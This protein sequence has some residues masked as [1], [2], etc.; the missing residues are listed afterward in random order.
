MCN[1]CFNFQLLWTV[2]KCPSFGKC[3]EVKWVPSYTYLIFPHFHVLMN[4]FFPKM[5]WKEGKQTRKIPHCGRSTTSPLVTWTY[6]SAS[7]S[8]PGAERR[9]KQNT[10]C[11][12]R[13]VALLLTILPV[14]WI[15]THW[16]VF[17]GNPKSHRTVWVCVLAIVVH[18]KCVFSMEI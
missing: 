6:S 1:H 11:K 15:V 17:S 9:E 2:S 3:T 12:N 4:H 14:R 7:G 13:L 8:A 10:E 5:V 18:T 16:S